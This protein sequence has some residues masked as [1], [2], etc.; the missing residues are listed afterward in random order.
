MCAIRSAP[1]EPA[2]QT[3]RCNLPRPEPTSGR[4]ASIRIAVKILNLFPAPNSGLQ[5]YANSPN[6]FEHRN[7]FDVRGDVNPNE[8][9]QIFV[10]FSYSDDPH[11]IPGIFGGIADGG[12]FDQGMQTAKSDQAVAGYTHVFTPNTIN[13]VRAGFAH[14][15]TTRFGPE[16]TVRTEFRPVWHPGHSAG[17]GKRRPPRIRHRQPCSWAA[18]PSCHLTK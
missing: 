16:G 8:K 4:I 1:A 18:T 12:S 11:Y 15:H 5:T 14:L 17:P 6:L 13:Q 9:D 3:S 7:H 2:P 10:R